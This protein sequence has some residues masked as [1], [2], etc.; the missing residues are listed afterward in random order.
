MATT[1][2]S[3]DNSRAWLGQATRTRTRGAMTQ[4]STIELEAAFR[5][6]LALPDSLEPSFDAVLR[7]LLDHPGSMVRPRLVHQIALT[8]GLESEDAVELAIALEYFHTASLVFDDLP[9][10]D[11]ALSR[12]GAVCV[13]LPFGE[14]GAILGA[15]ALINRAYALTWKVLAGCAA[16]VQAQA[17]EYVE[18]RL[19]INGLLNGQSLDL[20]Y[21]ALPHDR[22]TTERIACGKT[23]S[24]IRLTLVLPAM[25]GG[26]EAREVQYL[27][28]MAS[29]WGLAYQIVDDLKDV[30]QSSAQSGKT[31]ARDIH[32]DRP[33]IALAAGVST[34]VERLTRLI[35]AGDRT[36]Q[37]L[38]A[39]RPA[40]L[41]L[42]QLR[43]DLQNELNRVSEK[44]YVV[45]A[46]GKA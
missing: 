5:S 15:L 34:A 24:L 46:H 22:E 19:G 42:A 10:M 39:A 17:M 27:E 8:Y 4:Q 32:L 25:L 41:F 43:A 6:S 7:H 2:T 36:L 12:R 1:V 23:V 33:N 38:V 11:N 26:A 44:A 31:S 21:A 16:G 14:A 13:H 35:D 28:R 40:L 45:S 20:N 9:C 30:L 3:I 37:K 18:Q 29:C